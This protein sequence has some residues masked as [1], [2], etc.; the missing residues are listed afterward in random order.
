MTRSKTL[1]VLVQQQ[2]RP[3]VISIYFLPILT[4]FSPISGQVELHEQDV[5]GSERI[6]QQAF[7]QEVMTE[8]GAAGRT[9]D[10]GYFSWADTVDMA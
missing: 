1:P 6:L 5:S 7:S 3:Q 8:D 4:Y 9:F 2:V 10:N